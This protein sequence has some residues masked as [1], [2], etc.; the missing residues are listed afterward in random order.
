MTIA[1]VC[2]EC[3]RTFRVRPNAADPRCPTCG[4]VDWEVR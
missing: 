3:G 2:Q 4:S 1:L